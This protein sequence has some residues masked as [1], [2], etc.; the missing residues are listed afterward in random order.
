MC[1]CGMWGTCVFCGGVCVVSGIHVCFVGASVCGRW[2]VC[3]CGMY[4]CVL[5]V[6][7]W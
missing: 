3:A 1:V 6:Y 7:V 2:G 5:W 4:M